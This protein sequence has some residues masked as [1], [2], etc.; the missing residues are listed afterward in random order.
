MSLQFCVSQQINTSAYTFKTTGIRVY[1]FEE[2]L[3]HVF[4]HWRESLDEFLSDGMI[5]WVAELGHSY[6]A[7]KMKEL[8][9]KEPFAAKILDFLRLANYFSEESLAELSQTLTAWETRREWEKLKERGDYFAAKN[10]PL[11]AIPLYKRALA[12]E[13]NPALLNNLGIQY[14]RTA[15]HD[16][17]TRCL[18]RA[19]SLAPKDFDILLHYIEAAILN[20]SFEKAAKAL[21]KAKKPDRA[22]ILFLTGL[23]AHEQKDYPAAL[24]H[25]E[26]AIQTDSS[27]FFYVSK[28]VDI[29]LLMRQYEKAL[30]TLRQTTQQDYSFH[31]KEAEIYAAW[32]NIPRAVKA[33]KQAVSQEEDPVL[34]AKLAAYHRQDYEPRMAEAAIQKALAIAPE[35]DIARLENA[36]I[37]KALGRTREYQG[38]LTEILRSFK[39]EYVNAL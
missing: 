37:K 10:E 4:H 33:M 13:E 29:H 9:N 8:T 28:A 25:Y 17:A 22:E 39:D 35:N 5:A 26:K 3:Y 20:G 11:K 30:E 14:M 6:L 7:A 32:G 16:D 12:F 36:R 15:A 21:K 1:T 31:A 27:V 19:L 18:T 2:V 24:A 34:Y 38:A 23:M